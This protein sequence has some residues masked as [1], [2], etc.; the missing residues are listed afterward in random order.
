MNIKH[1]KDRQKSIIAFC[2]IPAFVFPLFL[3]RDAMADN[4]T[5]DFKEA[6]SKDGCAAIP[7]LDDRNLCEERYEDQKRVCQGYTCQKADFDKDLAEYKEKSQN[8]QEANDRK[9]EEAAHDLEAKVEKLKA[10]LE[11][12]K[13]S[14]EERVEHCKDCLETRERVQRSFS[15][16]IEKIQRED[17]PELKEYISILIQKFKDGRDAHVVP[18]QDVTKAM[19]NCQAVSDASW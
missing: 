7:Y 16:A 4:K 18:M 19:S 12:Y 1:D 9:N 13:Q 5:D 2:L 11:A 10:K 15:D 6:A 14:A 8:L 3:A 17:S